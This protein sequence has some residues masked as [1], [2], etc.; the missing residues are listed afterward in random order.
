MSYQTDHIQ[1]MISEIDRVLR[2]TRSRQFWTI[3]SRYA[4][5]RQLLERCRNFLVMQQR[6]QSVN[7][8]A[9]QPSPKSTQMATEL[10]QL[11]QDV[12]QPLRSDV[13]VLANHRAALQEEIQALML[14]KAQLQSECNTYRQTLAT[15]LPVQPYPAIRLSAMDETELA[16]LQAIR[17]RTDF[18]LTSMD[19]SLQL[20]F[21]SMQKNVE[22]YQ[23]TLHTGLDRMHHLGYQGEVLFSTL[24]N[25]LAQ[26]VGREM[27]AAT[28]DDRSKSSLTNSPSLNELNAIASASQ[29]QDWP[30]DLSSNTIHQLDDL[31][32]INNRTDSR[33]DSRTD[34]DI[35]VSPSRQTVA[36][37]PMR[38]FPES[39]DTF[40][41]D[42]KA[43][44]KAFDKDSSP[45]RSLSPRTYTEELDPADLTSSP[46]IRPQQV[47]VTMDSSD[48]PLNP[49]Q[50]PQNEPNGA[51]NVTLDT[52]FGFFEEI[53]LDPASSDMTLTEIDQLFADV[54]SL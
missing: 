5:H 17:D 41:A 38:E 22:V 31:Y 35:E 23:T 33:P 14:Q 15:N 30:T 54:P 13:A 27:M 50:L 44:S 51:E 34:S 21:G 1:S 9:A 49:S 20:A 46:N 25:R 19:S 40:F 39:I 52:L 7:V 3:F 8:V 16:R 11:R 12:M 26:Q 29:H 48:E 32:Q 53:S 2:Q 45:D 24:V 42:F 4:I 28:T 6:P 18:L 37:P 36:P 47:Y 10:Q 43:D